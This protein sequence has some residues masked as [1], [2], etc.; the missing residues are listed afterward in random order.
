[1]N[2]GI[3]TA[4]SVEVKRLQRVYPPPKVVGR[5]KVVGR[6]FTVVKKV[7]KKIHDDP[8]AGSFC[9]P[10]DEQADAAPGYFQLVRRPMDL[11]SILVY[12]ERDLYSTHEEV[13]A[14][15]QQVWDNCRTYNGVAA[16][17][18]LGRVLCLYVDLLEAEFEEEWSKEILQADKQPGYWARWLADRHLLQSRAS[19]LVQHEIHTL[20]SYVTLGTPSAARP[21]RLG[22]AGIRCE[23]DVY[24]LSP[25]TVRA[26]LKYIE[27]HCKR[28]QQLDGPILVWERETPDESYSVYS[29]T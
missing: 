9:R 7:V 26:C 12:L 2:S 25:A 14:D 18:T 11:S 23:I 1:M 24:N 13:R 21:R 15:V 8:R 28:N 16:W 19:T 6:A 17:S 20:L 5:K 10:V 3:P 27:R 4:D 29:G 22:T